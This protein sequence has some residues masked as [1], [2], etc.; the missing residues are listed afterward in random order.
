MSGSYYFANYFYMFTYVYIYLYLMP[1]RTATFLYP[2][3]SAA[4]TY[5]SLSSQHG[6]F[7]GKDEIKDR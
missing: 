5:H 7:Y 1:H 3:L 6:V 2:K 4:L